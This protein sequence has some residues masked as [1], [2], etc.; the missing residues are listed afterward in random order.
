MTRYD[1][2]EALCYH[3]AYAQDNFCSMSRECKECSLSD[4]DGFCFCWKEKPDDEVT[5]PRFKY[6]YLRG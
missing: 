2:Y 3:C 1:D 6:R 5:C 4:N